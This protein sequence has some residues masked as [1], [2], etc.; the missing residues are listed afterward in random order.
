MSQTET[1]IEQRLQVLQDENKKLV[2]KDKELA[3][4]IQT[5]SRTRSQI[6]E[7]QQQIQGAVN[8]FAALIGQDKVSAMLN[9]IN[10]PA[11]EEPKKK[12]E[13]EVKEENKKE[14]TKPLEGEVIE[15]PKK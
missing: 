11:K 10:A 2:A 1:Q 9:K 7:R 13:K 3:E 15:K 4:Q 8:E 6:R 14:E 12:E 5:L